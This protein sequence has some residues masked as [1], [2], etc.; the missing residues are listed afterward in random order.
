MSSFSLSSEALEHILDAKTQT[1]L[2]ANKVSMSAIL[3]TLPAASSVSVTTVSETSSTSVSTA[4]KTHI[5]I[6]KW[7]DE[8]IPSEYF[9]N[10]E[11]AMAH[12]KMLEM[13]AGHLLSVYLSLRLFFTRM[14]AR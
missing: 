9:D 13:C 10:Y 11:K 7:S 1:F 6:P 8:D 12:Q 5:K 2:A 14:C 3:A 4:V